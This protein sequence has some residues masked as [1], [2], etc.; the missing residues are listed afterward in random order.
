MHTLMTTG[1]V[2]S[3]EGTRQAEKSDQTRRLILDAAIVCLSE[4][5][6]NKTTMTVIAKTA[7]LSRGAMQ[8]HFETMTDVL[9]AALAHIQDLRLDALR[10]TASETR[11][12][13]GSDGFAARVDGLWKIMFEPLSVAYFEISVASRTD[14][15]LA[16]L[17]QQ[18]Q[19]SFWDEWVA[20]ALEAFPEWEGRQ[21]DLELACGLA[22]AVL[23]GLALQQLTNQGSMVRSESVRAYLVD[24]VR[25]IFEHG[26]P[27]P[28]RN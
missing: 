8:Y 25:E 7:G 28:A 4:I 20:T 16:S 14:A 2:R 15:A 27:G 21:S 24:R 18:A 6:Y 17:M 10:R 1:R 9:R 23:E 3:R 12:H 26:T 13:S 19:Q 5:G 22:H 11:R